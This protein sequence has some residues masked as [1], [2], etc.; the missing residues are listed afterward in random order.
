MKYVE[1]LTGV[2]VS[3]GKKMWVRRENPE[4]KRG[5]EGAR[6]GSDCS[7]TH[8]WRDHV[9]FIPQSFVRCY[10]RE[11]SGDTIAQPQ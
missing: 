11:S 9:F 6:N 4:K 2:W 5:R 10:S 7:S 8:S 3:R 1:L